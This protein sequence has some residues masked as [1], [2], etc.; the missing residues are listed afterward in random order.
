MIFQSTQT[1]NPSPKHVSITEY[2]YL[3]FRK[4][5]NAR[6][7]LVLPE[8]CILIHALVESRL[9]PEPKQSA[10]RP[11]TNHNKTDMQVER[12]HPW[13]KAFNKSDRI[14]RPSQ[15][16]ACLR[17]FC[18]TTQP[19]LPAASTACRSAN[20]SA[21]SVWQLGRSSSKAVIFVAKCTLTSVGLSKT[22]TTHKHK[23]PPT[24]SLPAATTRPWPCGV[25]KAFSI[26]R[27][28]RGT[29]RSIR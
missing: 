29:L 1:K 7:F 24:D 28:C 23:H 21:T 20:A 18:D 16:E 22:R 13:T 14:R 25:G 19:L 8:E 12:G 10:A 2:H 6:H 4:G 9:R 26:L 5:Q 17:T 15:Y 27:N 3:Q 11:Q